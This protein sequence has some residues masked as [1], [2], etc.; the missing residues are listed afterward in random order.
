[1][2]AT[3][4]MLHFRVGEMHCV[5]IRKE[6][7]NATARLHTPETPTRSASRLTKISAS[8]VWIAQTMNFARVWTEQL[9]AFPAVQILAKFVGRMQTA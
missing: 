3:L 8:P 9:S 5:Q 4:R 2:N 7:T 1:M 6:V